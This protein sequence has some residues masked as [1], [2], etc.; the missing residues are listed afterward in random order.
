[1]SSSIFRR[2]A[3]SAQRL[4][5]NA[6]QTLAARGVDPSSFFLPSSEPSLS[7]T[8]DLPSP[9]DGELL[10]LGYSESSSKR[11][12]DAYL[13]AVDK[14]RDSCYERFRTICISLSSCVSHSTQSDWP[15]KVERSVRTRYTGHT[16]QLHKATLRI[17]Q[18]KMM[19]G[20]G[21]DLQT[22]ERPFNMVSVLLNVCVTQA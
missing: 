9:I 19:N 6:S 2:L 4:G 5:A 16:Q 17:L 8:L 15:A 7:F 18:E 22:T 21:D 3:G 1:M 12:S 11:F 20:S 10:A 13:G 14:I